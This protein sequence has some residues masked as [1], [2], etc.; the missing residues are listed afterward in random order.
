MERTTAGTVAAGASA[1]IRYSNLGLF[2]L[3]W[4]PQSLLCSLS[5]LTTPQLPLV[6]GFLIAPREILYIF[7]FAG[8]EGSTI[9]KLK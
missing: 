6:L 1:I 2:I 8:L 3:G 7:I 5:P 9:L 4:P